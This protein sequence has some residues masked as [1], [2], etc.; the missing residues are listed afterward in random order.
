[1]DAPV[2]VFPVDDDEV[3]E[4]VVL[5]EERRDGLL[6]VPP[7]H[8]EPTRELLSELCRHH[9]GGA[10][11]PEVPPVV[12]DAGVAEEEEGGAVAAVESRLTDVDAVCSKQLHRPR[13]Q[14]HLVVVRG[15]VAGVLRVCLPPPALDLA[16][17]IEDGRRN[18]RLRPEILLGCHNPRHYMCSR[19]GGEGRRGERS[20]GRCRGTSGG[21]GRDSWD[22]SEHRRIW[23]L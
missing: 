1:M 21:S 5:L 20:L 19:R 13:V 4:E 15:H 8:L 17:V 10:V 3:T 6:R 9:L 14:E 7:H 22:S 11:V 23:R 12:V 2:R 18:H 16:E